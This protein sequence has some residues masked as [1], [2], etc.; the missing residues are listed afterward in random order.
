MRFAKNL[1]SLNI[2]TVNVIAKKCGYNSTSYFVSSFKEYYGVTPCKFFE[3]INNKNNF[4]LGINDS[5]Y[6]NAIIN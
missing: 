2:Y 5:F 1:I 6:P 3:Y 4:C